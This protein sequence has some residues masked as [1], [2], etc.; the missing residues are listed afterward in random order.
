MKSTVDIIQAQ[1]DDCDNSK[2]SA[3]IVEKKRA[4]DTCIQDRLSVGERKP[5]SH[6]SLGYQAGPNP[7]GDLTTIWTCGHQ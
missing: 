1:I 7:I 2:K 5:L 6:A 3:S 4:H